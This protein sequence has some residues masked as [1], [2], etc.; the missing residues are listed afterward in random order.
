V[1]KN[2]QRDTL[3]READIAMAKTL[4]HAFTLIELMVVIGIIAIMIAFLLPALANARKQAKL[5]ACQSNLRQIGNLLLIY[6][7]ENA[8]WIYPVGDG[9][10]QAP[11]GPANLRRLG[12]ALPMAERW[13]VYVRGLDRWLN[14][15]LRCPVDVDS[16]NDVSY[17]LNYWLQAHGVKFGNTNLPDGISAHDFAVMGERLNG[18]RPDTGWYFFAKTSEYLEGADPYKHGLQRGSN[19]LF[20]DLH[21]AAVR[22]PQEVKWGFETEP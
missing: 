11:A 5:V 12:A 20:L 3:Q 16:P 6:A 21:V 2:H 19:Y 9:D 22:N 13:P 7:N 14:P 17:A 18:D 8:G 1:Q 10:P 4:R 15:L